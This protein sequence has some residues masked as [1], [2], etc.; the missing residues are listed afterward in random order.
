MNN[1][2]K[3]FLIATLI[4]GTLTTFGSENSQYVSSIGNG[5]TAKFNEKKD[6]NL[7]RGNSLV[8]QIEKGSPLYNELVEIRDNLV[9][10]KFG[11]DVIPLPV[12]SYHVTIFNGTNETAAQRKYGFFPEDMPLESSIFDVHQH[13]Y[14]KLKEAYESGAIKIKPIKFKI[15]ALDTKYGF[16]PTL[17]P[18]TEEDHKYLWELREQ[19]SK[20]LKIKRPSFNEDKFHISMA[21]L[22]KKMT[23]EQGAAYQKFADEQFKTMKNKTFTINH[24]EFV[25][26]NDMLSY[27]P[28]LEMKENQK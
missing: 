10:S 23:P 5:G 18:A 11:N 1:L 8:T 22:Y 7:Y 26:F 21:Y 27:S 3:L 14:K 2:K 19:F 4:T 15:V 9:K 13:F 16:S 28:L 24:V 6:A 20:L 12:N 25:I 17:E